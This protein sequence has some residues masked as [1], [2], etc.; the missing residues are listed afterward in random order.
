[1]KMN[2]H[3]KGHLMVLDETE[4][5]IIYEFYRL[6]CTIERMEDLIAQNGYDMTFKSDNDKEIVGK[7]IIELMDDYHVSEDE[8]INTVLDDADYMRNYIE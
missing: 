2:F 4:Q 6:H 7:R 8:A 5:S 3:H 1:M